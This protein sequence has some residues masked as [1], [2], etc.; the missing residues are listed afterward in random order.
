MAFARPDKK[1]IDPEVRAEPGTPQSEGP[2]GE[3]ADPL[4]LELDDKQLIKVLRKRIDDSKNFFKA[5][6]I[7]G[8]Q[9]VNKD[10]LF[11]NQL[12]DDP[13]PRKHERPYVENVIYRNWR[14]IKPVAMSRIPDIIVRP[15]PTNPGSE[16]ASKDLTKALTQRFK[17]EDMREVLGMA[18]KHR[19]V[20]FFG[21]I[22]HRWDPEIG[23]DGDYVFEWRHP[24]N[25]ILDHTA[26]ST[27]ANEHEFLGEWL[28]LTAKEILIRFPDKEKEFL[29]ALGWDKDDI[30]NETKLATKIKIAEIWFT[31]YNK[32]RNPEN[33]KLEFRR[34][35]A[36]AWIY[37]GARKGVVLKKMLNP[38]WDWRGEQ[39]FFIHNQPIDEAEIR[40]ALA[41][42][43][44]IAGLTSRRF[45]RNYLR[46]PEKPYILIGYDQW[47]EMP[48]DQ[49]SEIEQVILLQKALNRRGQD[50]T[51]QAERA[52]VKHVFSTE[53]GFDA[54]KIQRLNLADKDQDILVDGDID[55]A[56]RSIITPPPAPAQFGAQESV[57]RAIDAIMGAQAPLRGEIQS[58]VATTNQIAREGNISIIDD[59]VEETVNKAVKKMARSAL[60][61]VKLRYTRDHFEAVTGIEG[62]TTFIAINRDLVDDGMIVEVDASATD[63]VERKREAFEAARLNFTDPLTFNI[64]TGKSDP[65]KR[66]E[67]ALLFQAAPEL[68]LR[69]VIRGEGTQDM[70][71]SLQQGGQEMAQRIQQLVQTMRAPGF[72]P[73]S[74]EGQ[75]T[76]QEAQQLSQQIRGGANANPQ[77]QG[78]G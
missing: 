49:T 34:I 74:P 3:I 43:R 7:P 44:E 76:V 68:Y 70:A 30:E 64:D 32:E 38:N 18:T 15:S 33:G 71:D 29:K 19:P 17:K 50:I 11:G 73:Q 20:Y 60:Q 5:K 36:V 52:G 24:L 42:Q 27:D 57:E 45:Y 78:R 56:H 55:K 58:D 69:Q 31:W 8:R 48:I 59:M 62:Q 77:N 35:E 1:V 14:S 47:G 67:R 37:L 21:A 26:K 25:M 72:N 41:E 46:N 53:G 22:K 51:E 6:N 23:Q 65:A 66:A 12:R 4:K 61:Y 40:T 63:K 75:R 28:E 16:Q 10:F 9:Q 13:K 39:N 2:V 54:A